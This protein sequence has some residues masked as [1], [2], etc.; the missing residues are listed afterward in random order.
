MKIGYI[1]FGCILI[2]LCIMLFSCRKKVETMQEEI[3]E[4]ELYN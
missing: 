1:V 3:V 4:T 2:A